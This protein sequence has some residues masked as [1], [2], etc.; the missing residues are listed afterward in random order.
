VTSRIQG[1]IVELGLRPGDQLPSERELMGEFGVGRSAVREA[2]LSL[3]RM[4]I[5]S[6]SSGERARVGQL[7]TEVM[8]KQLSGLAQ[9]LLAQPK[10]IE[11]FQDARMLLEVGLARVAAQGATEYRGGLPLRRGRSVGGQSSPVERLDNRGRSGGI[12]SH[13][14]LRVPEY[15]GKLTFS[16]H[17]H[18]LAAFVRW[19]SAA[20]ATDGP[21]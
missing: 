20:G 12:H 3:Q 21:R 19:H 1:R 14:V 16:T 10:G 8:V 13:G 6:V 2:M 4:G 18:R 17:L 7:T 5:V 15:V 9:L 11:Q